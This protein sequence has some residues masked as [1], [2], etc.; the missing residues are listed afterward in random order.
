MSLSSFQKATLVWGAGG[1]ESGLK[2]SS[3]VGPAG[4]RMSPSS[5]LVHWMSVMADHAPPAPSPHDSVSPH[6][7]SAHY[8]WQT[9]ANG[10]EVSLQKNFIH[11]PWYCC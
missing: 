3:G 9:S 10:V 11:R 5:G 1:A 7:M 4:G 8:L 2:T 6:H